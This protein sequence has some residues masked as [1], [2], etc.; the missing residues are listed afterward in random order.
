MVYTAQ[1]LVMRNHL[2]RA[3]TGTAM[4]DSNTAWSGIGS[5]LLTLWRNIYFP[6]SVSGTLLAVLYLGLIAVFHITTPALFSV[7]TFNASVPVN[8]TLSGL[9]DYQ[10]SS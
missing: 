6:A 4:H 9:P 7:Q 5:G 10:D 8:L 3:T 2:S 1:Q